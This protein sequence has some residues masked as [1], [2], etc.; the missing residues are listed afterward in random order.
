MNSVQVGKA[1]FVKESY[2]TLGIVNTRLTKIS[3]AIFAPDER[4]PSSATLDAGT[5]FSSLTTPI[6][7]FQVQAAYKALCRS[8]ARKG[9]CIL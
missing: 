3:V 9:G 8:S 4:L 2:T 7:I 6:T 1:A 5:I